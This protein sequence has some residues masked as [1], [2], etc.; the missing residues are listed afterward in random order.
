MDEAQKYL[1]QSSPNKKTKHRYIT[2]LVQQN[3][4]YLED[5]ANGRVI[6]QRTG[7]RYNYYPQTRIAEWEPHQLFDKPEL[8]FTN[9]C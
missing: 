3:G 2:V 5:M 7:I 8:N 4:F 1:S 9:Y 6:D